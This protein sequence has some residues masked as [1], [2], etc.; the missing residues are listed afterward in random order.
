[1]TGYFH[2]YSMMVLLQADPKRL[3]SRSL[4]GG[5]AQSDLVFHA[6]VREARTRLRLTN[7]VTQFFEITVTKMQLLPAQAQPSRLLFHFRGWL[8]VLTK[9]CLD[10]IRLLPFPLV[11]SALPDTMNFSSVMYPVVTEDVTLFSPSKCFPLLLPLFFHLPCTY[12]PC[13]S[14]HFFEESLSGTKH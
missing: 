2:H 8:L 14:R 11:T 4:I 5:S 9:Q 13:S 12:C 7:I 1:M 10:L 6:S 3:G